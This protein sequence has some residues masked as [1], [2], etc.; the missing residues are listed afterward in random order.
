LNHHIEDIYKELDV[1]M[2]RIGQ[3]QVQ[4]DGLIATVKKL[5]E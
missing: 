1:Q 4:I 2:K 3:M 5:S